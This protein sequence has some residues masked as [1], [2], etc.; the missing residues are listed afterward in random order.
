[1]AKAV[2]K[3]ELYSSLWDSCDQLRGSMDA[4]QYKDYVLTLLFVKYV[5]DKATGNPYEEI[6]VPDGGSFVDMVA[7]KNK[8]NIGEGMD[9]IIG[10]LAEANGLQGVITNAHFNDDAKLGRGKE[11]VDT[12]TKLI[13]IFQR[14]E[15]DFSRN[16]ANDDDLIGDAYEYLMR[17]FAT[18]SGKSKGQFYTP[19]EVA[20]VLAKVVEVGSCTDPQATVYDPACGSGSL[21]I[22]VLAEAPFELAG[23][24]QEKDNATAGLA[25]MNAVLHGK[26]T[27]NIY[28]GNTFADPHNFDTG[29]NNSLQRFDYVVANPPF[30][31]KNWKNGLE[32]GLER[33]QGYGDEPPEKNGDYAWLMHILASL[34]GT[35]KAA[36]IL[37][38][39]VLFRGNAEGTIR[40]TI[41]SEK[42]WIKAIIGLPQNLFYGTG[43]PACIVVIDKSHADSR[44]HVFM[45]DASRDFV[46]DG[47]KNRLRECDIFRIVETY[48]NELED[49]PT[50]SRKVPIS[51]IIDK[52][53]CNLNLSRYLQNPNVEDVQDIDGHLRGGIPV[54]DVDSL[55]RYWK[56]FPGLRDKLFEPM[57]DGYVELRVDNGRLLEAMEQDEAYAAYR[58]RIDEAYHSWMTEIRLHLLRLS[59][60]HDADISDELSSALLQA[61]SGIELMDRYD[62][63]QAIMAYWDDVMADDVQL[64][65]RDGWGVARELDIEH[66]TRTKTKNGEK[67]TVETEQIKSFDGVV[68]PATLVEK[69]YFP[70]ESR[71]CELCA[72]LEAKDEAEVYAMVEEADEDSELYDL[73]QTDTVNAANVASRLDDILG[74]A[75][76]AS[77]RELV[78]FQEWFAAERRK[79]PAYTA[80]IHEHPLCAVAVNDKGNVTKTSLAEAVRVARAEAGPSDDYRDDYEELR[81]VKRLLDEASEAKAQLK[82]LRQALDERIMAKYAALTDE[83]IQH[84]LIDRKWFFGIYGGI[85]ASYK[86]LTSSFVSRI[87]ELTERYE[88]TLPEL[89]NQVSALESKVLAHLAEMGFAW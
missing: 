20:R 80:Y 74:N 65:A 1:M 71:A 21:L 19:A 41:V 84:L 15:L 49:D 9:K 18:E 26:P 33:F 58:D 22:R 53:D 50:Y 52:N 73:A 48:E 25:K 76:S 27:V 63:Y 2:K 31:M 37:P 59:S 66:R 75:D 69:E 4:S 60:S 82:Q 62:V 24:G 35:G 67:V 36:V 43:I 78:A 51:E 17:K 13:G 14:P 85:D 68:L 56:S 83:E 87:N 6:V 46:K 3:S 10:K 81:K 7:L 86:K 5:S 40:R 77:I 44:E 23:Y 45:I 61:F 12:L 28:T 70:D 30:S 38:H 8:P 57:R 64:I 89:T 55:E 72:A 32:R 39:G 11:K 42:R 29:T 16:G 79:K 88:T 34:K 47:N 54:R